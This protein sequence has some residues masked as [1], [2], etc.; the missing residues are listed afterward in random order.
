MKI[1]MRNLLDNSWKFTA[2][3]EETI[4]EFKSIIKNNKT[5]F[6]VSD[7]GA[8]F[9]MKYSAKLFTPFQRLHAVTEFS[10][11][12]IGLAI[13]NRIIKRHGGTIWAESVVNVGTSIYF[14][15]N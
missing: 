8:G 5:I 10:G 13:V 4:L 3:K 11:T 12:G 7:N 2:K 6:C 9:D 14:T 15:F 1:M